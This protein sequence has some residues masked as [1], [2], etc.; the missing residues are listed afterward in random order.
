[1]FRQASLNLTAL[2]EGRLGK[3]VEYF[4]NTQKIENLLISFNVFKKLT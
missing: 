2:P 3:I 4:W 1:M